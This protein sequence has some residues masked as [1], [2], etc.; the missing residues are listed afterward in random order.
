V[1]IK[2]ALKV[3]F[4]INNQIKIRRFEELLWGTLAINYLSGSK[5]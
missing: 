3:F 1:G 4:S 5:I 2:I